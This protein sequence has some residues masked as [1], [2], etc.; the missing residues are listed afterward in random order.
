MKYEKNDIIEISKLVKRQKYSLKFECP[1][2]GRKT[3]A[4]KIL[5]EPGCVHFEGFDELF[6]MT[7]DF[8]HVDI[9]KV[10]GLV[11]KFTI[12]PNRKPQITI[13]KSCIGVFDDDRFE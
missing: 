6:G 8:K 3:T 13:T 4:R 1:Y 10:V 2:C 12:K 5:T 7:P 9:S 11:A